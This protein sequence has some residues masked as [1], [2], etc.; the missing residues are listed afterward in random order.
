[1]F[2]FCT[3]FILYLLCDY[4]LILAS[5]NSVFQNQPSLDAFR[6][7][8][9]EDVFSPDYLS[10]CLPLLWWVGH[11]NDTPELTDIYVIYVN[12]SGLSRVFHAGSNWWVMELVTQKPPKL[13]ILMSCIPACQAFRGPM[14]RN[15]VDQSFSATMTAYSLGECSDYLYSMLLI[16]IL[17]L[18][19]PHHQERN[20]FQGKEPRIQI[21]LTYSH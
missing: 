15:A 20:V 6:R 3:E 18:S 9:P 21:P 2:Y 10:I 12:L 1:M 11:Q 5:L 17:I 14:G 13:M 7:F 19:L 8:S 4:G 16:K